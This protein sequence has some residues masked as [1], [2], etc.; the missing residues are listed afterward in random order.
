MSSRSCSRTLATAFGVT[1]LLLVEASAQ[2]NFR[3]AANSTVKY[4]QPVAAPKIACKA[5]RERM[6]NFN[7]S[8]VSATLLPAQAGVPEHCRVYG[9]IQ[10]E[11]RFEVN[12]PTAWN[13][14]FYMHGNGGTAGQK[15]GHPA[16]ASTRNAA[17]RN[18]F[19]TTW[20]DTGH[21]EFSHPLFSFAHDN[22]YRVVDF[23]FR[24]IHLTAVTAK[25]VVRAYYEL[26]AKY[27]YFDGCSLGGRQALVSAQRFPS[28]FNG[29]SVGAP[30]LDT[31][32]VG[33]WNAKALEDAPIAYDKIDLIAEAVYRNCDGKDGLVDGII[34]DPRRCDFDPER[35]LPKCPGDVDGS[36]CFTNA[37]IGALKKIYGGIVSKG[38][39]V[40]PGNPVGA[41]AAGQQGVPPRHPPGE[42]VSGWDFWLIDRAGPGQLANFSESALKYLTFEKDDPKYN[43]RDFSFDRD[44]ERLAGNAEYMDARDPDLS[45]FRVAGGKM[46]MRHGWADMSLNPLITI[47][48][49]EKVTA[50]MGAQTSDFFRFFPVPGMFHCSGGV[51]VTSI[52]PMTALINWVEGGVAPETLPGSRVERGTVTLTRPLC[53]YPKVARYRGQGPANDAAS[54]ACAS[55]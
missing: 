44:Y 42:K 40:F 46:I 15:P 13:G 45:A 28:D 3:D 20:N 50:T 53:P 51:G 8:I 1:C 5:L 4:A 23:G 17:L 16:M 19:A 21:D 52:D 37:Q 39:V 32:M 29:I 12:L 25:D 55:P 24:A 54:F 9:V 2:S 47:D 48:Y 38:R 14:R 43:W 26:P 36:R 10:P 30:V 49:F 33:L 7:V 18:G 27:S 35:H 31:G 41:E 6:T 22:L 11:I 34:D